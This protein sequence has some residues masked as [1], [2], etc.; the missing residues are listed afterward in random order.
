MYEAFLYNIH[1]TQ[2]KNQQNNRKRKMKVKLWGRDRTLFT[3]RRT[4]PKSYLPKRRYAISI[5]RPPPASG[6]TSVPTA[7]HDKEEEAEEESLPG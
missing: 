2:P 7:D 4:R 3:P 5:V 1:T 6:S